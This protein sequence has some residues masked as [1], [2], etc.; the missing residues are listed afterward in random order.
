MFASAVESDLGVRWKKGTAVDTGL[1]NP[2]SPGLA[3]EK[4]NPGK[5][6]EFWAGRRK[7]DS[8]RQ[9]GDNS[10]KGERE[11]ATQETGAEAWIIDHGGNGKGPSCCCGAEHTKDAE[12]RNSI[13]TW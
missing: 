12:A 2:M 7:K 1:L 13:V 10:W 6:W 11:G 4:Q 9:M 8:G 5:A 3:E